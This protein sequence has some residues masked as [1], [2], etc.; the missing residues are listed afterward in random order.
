MSSINP[1]YLS[2]PNFFRIMAQKRDK[3]SL[4]SCA[5][6]PPH[7]H[8]HPPSSGGLSPLAN[9]VTMWKLALP[10]VPL[11][12]PNISGVQQKD[13]KPKPNKQKHREKFEYYLPYF[14]WSKSFATTVRSKLHSALSGSLSLSLSFSLS[15]SAL[16][17]ARCTEGPSKLSPQRGTSKHPWFFLFVLKGSGPY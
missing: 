17:L 5:P 6:P 13:T 16:W 3:R 1:S 4:L 15:L 12:L 10:L 9:A 2:P 14:G 8:P 7:P 11:L